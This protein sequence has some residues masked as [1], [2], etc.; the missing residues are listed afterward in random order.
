MAEIKIIELPKALSYDDVKVGD[1]ICY[2]IYVTYGW[3]TC[4]RH[5][6]F[7]ET[8]IARITPKKTKIVCED[9]HELNRNQDKIYPVT[10][11][12][13]LST[14]LATMFKFC[15]LNNDIL[16]DE[17]LAKLSQNDLRN[18]YHHLLSIKKILEPTE[19]GQ[20]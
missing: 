11:A 8:K 16:K 13:A 18:V 6:K 5:P 10:E 1:T 7:I 3:N 20:V 15:H 12:T 17:V 4:Y 19:E 2:K 9:G 14:S